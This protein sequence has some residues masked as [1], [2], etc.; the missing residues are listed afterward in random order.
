M[1]SA[2]VQSVNGVQVM[3][4]V[5]NAAKVGDNVNKTYCGGADWGSFW[6]RLTGQK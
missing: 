6:A 2:T 3:S 5:C 4:T 1:F